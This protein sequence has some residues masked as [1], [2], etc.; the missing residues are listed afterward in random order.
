MLE[1]KMDAEG[2]NTHALHPVTVGSNAT[3]TLA[4]QESTGSQ[5]RPEDILMFLL[6]PQ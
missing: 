4:S 3:I 6:G 5:T 2:L 1:P